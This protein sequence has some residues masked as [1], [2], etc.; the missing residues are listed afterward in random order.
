MSSPVRKVGAKVELDG[1]KEYKQAIS[2]LNAGN[3]TLASEMKKLQAEYKGNTEST[4]YLTKAG[5]LLEQQLL[6]QQDKVKKL[7]EIVAKVTKENGEASTQTQYW[8]QQLNNAQAAEYDLQ[9]AIEENN[10]ALQGQDKEMSGLGDTVDQLAGKFGINLPA[11]AKNALNGIQGL[12]AGTVAAMGVAAA[13]VAAVIEAVKQLGQ[14]TL[15]VAAQADEYITES[16]I[17]GVPTEML[18]AWDYAAPLIDVDADTIKGAMTKLT[19][20]MDDAR[21]GSGKSA[22]SFERLGISVTDSSGN[23]RSAEDVFYEAIDALGQVGNQTERDALAMDLMGKSAQDLNPL[24]NQG[25][26]ALKDMAKE[27]KNVGYI[28]D[29][30]QI[31]KLGEVDDAYQKLQL[32]IEANRRQLAADFAPAAKAA[33][34]LFSDSVQKAGEMLERS[35]LIT[36]LASIIESLTSILRTAGEIL[37]GIPA[38][39]S[40]LDALRVVLGGIAQFCALIADTADVIAGLLTMDFSRIGTAMG[41]GKSSGNPSHWQT[42]YMQQSGTYDQY[43]EYYANK[44]GQTTLSQYA[45]YGYDPSTGSYQYYDKYGNFIYGSNA[46]GT[47]NWRGGLTWVGENGPE[48]LRLPQGSQIMNAQESRKIGG[49][50]FNITIDA[51][52]IREFCDIIEIAQSARVRARMR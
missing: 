16:M 39:N 4:E 40:G 46:G 11:G 31:K 30:E 5:Q 8:V 50:T 45:G 32:T 48:L 27:A 10:K 47:D 36:N 44:R 19:N 37:S 26:A 12:S 42:V 29:E 49:D 7:Q 24:I 43:Q 34:E 38:F 51:A 22:E 52:S 17:T 14:I 6:Q 35:G 28:L 9:H 21:D 20:A 15:D 41:Y 23:L 33:M 25:S 2:E 3:R 13:A 18:Q 1:E